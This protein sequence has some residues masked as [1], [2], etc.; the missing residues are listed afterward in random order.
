M[1]VDSLDADE[2]G[3]CDAIDQCPDTNPAFLVD[4]FGCPLPCQTTLNITDTIGT[5]IYQA[6]QFIISDGLILNPGNV[7]FKAGIDIL[8]H[9]G[10]EIELGAEFLAE[11]QDCP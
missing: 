5:G 7:E 3:V 10:F 8:L 6:D 1:T 11:I 4:A 2:D 9:M